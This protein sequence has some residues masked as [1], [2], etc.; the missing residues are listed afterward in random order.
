M[1]ITERGAW[2][3]WAALA[4]VSLLY[5]LTSL[6]RRRR[7]SGSRRPLPPGPRPLPIIGNALDLRGANLHHAL[8]RLA[9]A[10]GD[11]MRL[12]LGPSGAAVVVVSSPAAAREAF[13]RHDRRHA[14]RVVPDAVRALG[15][16]DRSMIWLPSSDPRWKALRGVVAAHVVSPRSLASARGARERAVR[17][18][19]AHLRGR[20]GREV[21]V[22]RALYAAMLNLV[23]SSFFSVDLVDMDSGAESAH[24]IRHHVEEVANLMTRTNVSDLFPFLRPL[25]LQ[26]LHRKATVHLGEIFRILD[27]I[28]DR[29][30]AENSSSSGDK[31]GDFLDALVNL[32]SAGEISRE[33]ATTI[34]FDVLA[35]GSDTTAVTVEWAMALLL[36]N[37]DAMARA[38]AEIGSALGRK[39]SVAEPDAARLLYLQAVVKEAMRLRPVTPV[40]IPHKATEDGLEIGG[41]AVPRGSTVIFNAWAMMQD[42]TAWERPEEFVPERFLSSGRA[43]GVDFK[44]KDYEFIPFGSGRRQC[45]GLP[46]AELVVPHVLAALLH[47]FEWRLP[48]GVP[49]EQLDVSDRFTTANVMAVPLKAVPIVITKSQV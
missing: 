47:A 49:A 1:K 14:A 36:R 40:L 43:A 42:A 12:Q 19:V 41:Y 26:G 6:G 15:W 18:L 4:V 32:M 45:P 10:H 44:G 27:S 28:I 2:L 33:D 38:R 25:D 23:S 22:G 34:G 24:G 21:E 16:A 8:A 31:R 48:D 7:C 20:A 39:E 5:Y 46:L 11:V 37:P 17:G 3:L 9:R 29:R 30:L 35:A 13:A